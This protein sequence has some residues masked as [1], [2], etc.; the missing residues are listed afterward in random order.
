M[1]RKPEGATHSSGV[2]IRKAANRPQCGLVSLHSE[3]P[4]HLAETELAPLQHLWASLSMP[5]P[6][7]GSSC[8]ARDPW[9]LGRPL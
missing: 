1:N 9:G 7:L 3:Q 5:E 6:E 2:S 4:Q 8:L